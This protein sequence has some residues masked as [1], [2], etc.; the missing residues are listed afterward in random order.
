MLTLDFEGSILTRGVINLLQ[1]FFQA[2]SASQKIH[3]LHPECSWEISGELQG[4]LMFLNKCTFMEYSV[5][6]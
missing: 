6:L 3:Q 1:L 2:A 4:G 5:L